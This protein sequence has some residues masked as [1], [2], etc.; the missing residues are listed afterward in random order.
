MRPELIAELR[1][2]QRAVTD[3]TLHWTKRCEADVPWTNALR[4]NASALLSAAEEQQRLR[5]ALLKRVQEDNTCLGRNGEWLRGNSSPR[6]AVEPPCGA[7][8]GKW[9]SEKCGCAEEARSA[10][11]QEGT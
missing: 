7:G 1:R 2:M 9:D 10:L 6:Q 5:N 3:R 4:A 8:G 11:A